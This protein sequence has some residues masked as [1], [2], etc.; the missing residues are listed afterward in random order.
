MLHGVAVIAQAPQGQYVSRHRIARQFDLPESHLA[1]HL[2]SLVRAGVLHASTGPKGGFRLARD[3]HEISA[4]EVVE[5]VE[6][7][8]VRFTC[9]EIRQRGA[10][11]ASPAECRQRCAIAKMMDNAQAAWRQSLSEVSVADLVKTTPLRIRRANAAALSS[12]D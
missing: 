10:A 11:A 5:A 7:D 12:R 4:L 2:K 3:P 6:G 1:K 8:A 9:Q